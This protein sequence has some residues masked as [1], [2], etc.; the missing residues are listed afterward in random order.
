MDFGK[1]DLHFEDTLTEGDKVTYE[2][3]VEERT[4]KPK[5]AS[6]SVISAT[7]GANLLTLSGNPYGAYGVV[8]GG[9][10][11]T[12]IITSLDRV[13]PYGVPGAGGSEGSV[14]AGR[15]GSGAVAVLPAP[16]LAVPPTLLPGLANTQML[17]APGLATRLQM[18][19]P[20]AAAAPFGLPAGWEMTTDPASGKLY[21]F[22]R[23]TQESSWTVPT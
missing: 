7:A 18:V 5:A 12:S 2:V 13:S 4:Q 16:A 22:N 17:S 1:I 3:E 10:G 19:A 9:Y 8:V 6:W 11:P 21:Y 15:A 23:A 20:G 14:Q